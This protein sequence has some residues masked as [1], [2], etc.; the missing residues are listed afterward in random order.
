MIKPTAIRP[1]DCI[2]LISPASGME[3]SFLKGG[4]DWLEGQ[5]FKIKKG[6]FIQEKKGFLAGSIQQRVYDLH[7]M[8]ED[9]EVKGILCIRGG[10][11][12]LPLLPHIDYDGIKNNPKVFVGY[13]DITAL[14]L[15]IG[16][17]TGLITFHG[18]M[19]AELGEDVP[20]DNKAML[21]KALME[22]KPLGEI[23]FP[24][25]SLGLKTIY[26]GRATGR[27][28][29]GNL[30]VICATLGTPFEIDCKNKILILEEVGE[31]NYKIHRMLSQL[32]LAGKLEDA[33]GFILGEFTNCPEDA[34][35]PLEEILEEFFVP[36]KKPTLW[37]VKCGHGRYKATLPLGCQASI[38]NE[39][40]IL[41]EAGISG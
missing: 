27:L 30:S 5:G 36:L 16:Q 11:G 17:R 39:K 14:H 8:F 4:I 40:L 31:A 26:P 34:Q 13:S 20:S 24:K 7:Q 9:P 15:A 18:P 3:L 1:G 35:Y 28:I 19:V 38:V 41:E 21:K 22:K 12:T 25:D 33:L 37:G 10:Y 23:T 6:K 29:G 32:N 2:G